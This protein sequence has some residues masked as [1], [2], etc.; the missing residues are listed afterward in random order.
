MSPTEK[1]T[2]S[3]GQ[4][5]GCEPF[6]F[7]GTLRKPWITCLFSHLYANTSVV[8]AQYSQFDHLGEN[9]MLLMPEQ[10][11]SY[12]EPSIQVKKR[13]RRIRV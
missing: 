3:L 4:I 8:A 1:N 6:L 9:A 2:S 10:L 7:D 5:Q 13:Q 11:C 12:T